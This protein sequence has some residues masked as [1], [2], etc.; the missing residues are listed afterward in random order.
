MLAQPNDPP[1]RHR[2]MTWWITL[3]VGCALMAITL[4]IGLFL[5][6]G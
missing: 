2:G 6:L 1:V 4:L 3:G 5:M